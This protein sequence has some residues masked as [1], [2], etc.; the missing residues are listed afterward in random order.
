MSIF[1]WILVAIAAMCVFMGLSVAF[2]S[3]TWDDDK[4]GGLFEF[5]HPLLSVL[6]FPMLF[7]VPV[8]AVFYAMFVPMGEPKLWLQV[9]FRFLILF[10]VMTGSTYIFFIVTAFGLGV[11]RWTRKLR[12]TAIE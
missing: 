1:S 2:D 3:K 9:I 6:N 7:I 8:L 5:R 12:K 4:P 11:R 10:G